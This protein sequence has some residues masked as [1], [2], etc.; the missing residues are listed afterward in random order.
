MNSWKPITRKKPMIDGVD[1]EAHGLLNVL[2][3]L[4]CDPPDE[5]RCFFE[6]PVGVTISLDIH[7]PRIKGDEIWIRPPDEDMERYI[8]Y[9]DERIK[10]ANNFYEKEVLPRIIQQQQAEESAKIKHEKR[11]RDAEKRLANL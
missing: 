11:L 10:S 5:W 9:V 1:P 6:N 8:R 7:P 4:D 3:P 2:I